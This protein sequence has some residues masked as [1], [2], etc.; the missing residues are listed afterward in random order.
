M[1]SKAAVLREL[2]KRESIK[3]QKIYV[4]CE[5]YDFTWYKHEI[6][7]VRKMWNEGI[8]IIG[9]AKVVGRHLNE[10]AFL[11]MDQ[12]ERTKYVEA[13]RKKVTN[14]ISAFENLVSEKISYLQQRKYIACECFNFVWDEQEVFQ[15]RQLWESGASIFDISKAFKRNVNEIAF[16]IV[17]QA[18]QGYI[19][20]RKGG[21][22]GEF[23]ESKCD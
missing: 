20:A 18:D 5:H 1:S 19:K 10:V 6:T 3:R 21:V 12:A 14:D 17:D 8:S 4:A 22:L 23:F 16:L 15:F 2:R 11:I 13:R 7:L 9:I